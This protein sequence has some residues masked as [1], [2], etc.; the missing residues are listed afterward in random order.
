MGPFDS[1]NPA[2]RGVHRYT[3]ESN[4]IHTRM[5]DASHSRSHNKWLVLIAVYK[6]LQAVLFAALGVGALRL[7]HK[8][9]GYLFADLADWMRFNPEAR[10][11]HYLLVKASLINDPILR[12]IG[13][14][15][16]S[17][18][19][20]SLVEGIGLYLEKTWGELLT[21]VITASF[22][23]WEI[24]EVFRL[25]TPFRAAL[26]AIN[27]LVFLYLLKLVSGGRR[28]GNRRMRA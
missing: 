11:V 14:A 26:L 6:F 23:P 16:L 10:V 17:Y 9:I 22:L 27:M 1:T 19:G 12:R 2:D 7:L 4:R 8:D 15:A 24:F 3:K 28:P 5:N 21:L 18:A 20:I 13:L 25:H